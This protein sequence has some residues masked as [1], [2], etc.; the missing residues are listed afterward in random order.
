M[1]TFDPDLLRNIETMVHSEATKLCVELVDN[2]NTRPIKKAALIRDI[3]EAPN[4]SE[5]S[6]IMWN[7]LL[8]GEGLITLGS[9][10]QKM[11][12]K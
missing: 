2:S 4:S 3:K 6:R 9:S 10:W 11:Y 7:V 5:L 12:G 1:D 8:S